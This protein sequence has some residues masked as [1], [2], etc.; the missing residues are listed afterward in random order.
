[1]E[2]A[3]KKNRAVLA[4]CL[5]ILTGILIPAGF[6]LRGHAKT[7][8]VTQHLVIVP[9]IPPVDLEKE[10]RKLNGRGFT[11]SKDHLIVVGD[12]FTIFVDADDSDQPD[13]ADS[14]D[15]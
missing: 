4:R 1:M 3:M 14:G 6:Y 8:H 11:V 9:D 7:Q 13:E 12:K 15:R 2:G 5:L 10:I